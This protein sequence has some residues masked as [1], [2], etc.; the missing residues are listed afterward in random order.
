MAPILDS[1]Q[2]KHFENFMAALTDHVKKMIFTPGEVLTLAVLMGHARNC[3]RYSVVR[4]MLVVLHLALNIKVTGSNSIP[5]KAANIIEYLRIGDNTSETSLE[6]E[7]REIIT[8]H[9]YFTCDC[10]FH[11]DLNVP[12]NW[13]A[14]EKCGSN[15]EEVETEIKTKKTSQR[16][17]TTYVPEVEIREELQYKVQI[18]LQRQLANSFVISQP[19]TR[20][21]QEQYCKA[22]HMTYSRDHMIVFLIRLMDHFPR[23]NLEF[24]HQKLHKLEV[25]IMQLC[26]CTHHVKFR[27]MTQ[28]NSNSILGWINMLKANKRME[29]TPLRIRLGGPN[30]QYLLPQLWDC[31]SLSKTIGMYIPKRIKEATKGALVMNLLQG[32]PESQIEVARLYWAINEYTEVMSRQG[33][34]QLGQV[35]MSSA[36][37]RTF[38]HIFRSRPRGPIYGVPMSPI[39]HPSQVMSVPSIPTMANLTAYAAATPPVITPPKRPRFLPPSEAKP[40]EQNVA[41]PLEFRLVGM[42]HTSVTY[43]LNLPTSNPVRESL[44]N[45]SS[46]KRKIE[47]QVKMPSNSYSQQIV[48]PRVPQQ[49]SMRMERPIQPK[50]SE[51]KYFPPGPQKVIRTPVHILKREVFSPLP[52]SASE[53]RTTSESPIK[54]LTK[55]QEM[56]AIQ[57]M[58]AKPS[59][60]A[61]TRNISSTQE[62]PLGEVKPITGR[63]V[64]QNEGLPVVQEE[65]SDETVSS[66]NLD[67]EEIMEGIQE[68]TASSTESTKS[69]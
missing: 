6:N 2:F 30:K 57:E 14:F 26:P 19:M 17:D 23:E 38:V 46:T 44:G 11:C 53:K 15:W 54:E 10:K 20:D 4:R 24:L 69:G 9:Y 13:L 65:K 60:S 56:Q 21:E 48:K 55:L 31:E 12:P 29:D 41:K 18:L 64:S 49:P 1:A 28:Y 61:V 40:V 51:Q 34:S 39:V 47:E 33:N 59:S 52:R 67:L 7:V 25:A 66:D 43:Q 36:S 68:G 62:K 16:L 63:D 42:S 22:N 45:V 3:T 37:Y 50:A 27:E 8:H 32:K 58:Q 35:W 5:N